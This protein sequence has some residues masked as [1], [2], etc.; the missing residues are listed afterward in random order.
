MAG[1][2]MAPAVPA[3]ATPEA[4]AA[5]TKTFYERSVVVAADAR[6]RLFTPQVTAALKAS[7]LQARGAAARAG[8]DDTSLIEAGLKAQS[9]ADRT[10]CADPDLATIRERVTQA[11]SGWTRLRQMEFPG[12]RA[13]WTA[14]R[15]TFTDPAWR[16][17]QTGASGGASVD[18]GLVAGGGALDE[19]AAVV[20]FPGKS[21]PYAARIVMRDA[22]RL[23]RP[24]LIDG[25]AALP[26]ETGR[27]T[28]YAGA[29]CEAAPTL[30]AEGRKQGEVWT[31]GADAAERLAALDPREPFVIEFL[32]RDD[33]VA[34]A[35]FEVGDLAAGRAF[36]AMGS[37]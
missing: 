6:C 24:W 26:P 14:D 36:T 22:D 4:Q 33:S 3:G 1:A 13:G 18:F 28:L 10:S 27:Q 21:R 17:V 5:V 37:L 30:L 2:L 11:Y 34:R 35:R 25:A 23:A 32:F 19:V 29:S 7:T 8:A 16:L 9:L 15:T 31:F 12:E 20:S